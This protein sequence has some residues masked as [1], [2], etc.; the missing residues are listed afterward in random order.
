MI[1]SMFTANS[2]RRISKIK[3]LP[4]WL[5]SIQTSQ[6]TE[7][8]KVVIII[9]I[10]SM[11]DAVV[12]TMETLLAED[13]ED[14]EEAAAVVAGEE[15]IASIYR[16]YS[17]SSGPNKSNIGGD[18]QYQHNNNSMT[19]NPSLLSVSHHDEDHSNYGNGIGNNDRRHQQRG[20][21][22]RVLLTSDDASNLRA[23]KYSRQ[24]M[25]ECW[26]YL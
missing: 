18:F 23:P 16:A 8:E 13:A 12:I 10:I 17:F 26:H 22:E 25:M 24:T 5:A 4:K 1:S 11:A 7:R 9:I 21:D 3:S 20:C 2:G 19:V 15:T 14:V 6:M